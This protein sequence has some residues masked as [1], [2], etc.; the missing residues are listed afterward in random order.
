LGTFYTTDVGKPDVYKTPAR[1]LK[2]DENTGKITGKY[3]QPD[4]FLMGTVAGMAKVYICIIYMYVCLF[5]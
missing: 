2:V 4:E 3:S 1:M 5:V